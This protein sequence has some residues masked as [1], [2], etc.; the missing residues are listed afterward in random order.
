MNAQP[1]A[2]MTTRAD[3]WHGAAGRRRGHLARAVIMGA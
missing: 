2:N 3:S 1:K